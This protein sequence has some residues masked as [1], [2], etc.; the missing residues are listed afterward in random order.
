[1]WDWKHPENTSGIPHFP[2]K[3]ASCQIDAD[4][5][6]SLAHCLSWLLGPKD[7]R[8]SGL[9]GPRAQGQSPAGGYHRPKTF[10]KKQKAAGSLRRPTKAEGRRPTTLSKAEDPRPKAE[11]RRPKTKGHRPRADTRGPKAEGLQLEDNQ[12]TTSRQPMFCGDSCNSRFVQSK[13]EQSF[14]FWARSKTSQ[15]LVK[16]WLSTSCLWF[17]IY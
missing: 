7:H 12:K 9:K 2:I 3:Y 1:M 11:D 8:A 17:D 6:F 14:L 4:S 5:G 16:P 13:R 15:I 10:G